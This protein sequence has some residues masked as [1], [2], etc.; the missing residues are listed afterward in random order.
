QVSFTDRWPLQPTMVFEREYHPNLAMSLSEKRDL[1]SQPSALVAWMYEPRRRQLVGDT[2]GVSV[3]A[4]LAEEDK[5]GQ[6][7]LR[8]FEGRCALYIYS[9]TILPPYRRAGLGRILKAYL[10]GRAFEAGYHYAVGHAG[11]GASIALN[12]AF[13]AKLGRSHA[14][15]YDTGECYRFYVQK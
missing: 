8:P 13:G 11:P 15:W 6:E 5:E 14:N 12:Q 4:V 7:E 9:T 1:L 10:L 3:Q 2:Y